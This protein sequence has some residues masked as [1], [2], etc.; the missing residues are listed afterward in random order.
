M[1]IAPGVICPF[2][3]PA[4]SGFSQHQHIKA[5]RK[6]PG[7]DLV[8]FGEAKATSIPVHISQVSSVLVQAIAGL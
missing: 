2:I 8:Q 1:H 5:L 4:P 6:G 3:G 7:F